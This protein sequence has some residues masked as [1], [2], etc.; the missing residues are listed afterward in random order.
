VRT[1]TA[2]IDVVGADFIVEAQADKTAVYCI[3]G[4][5]SVRNILPDIAE[6]FILHAGE[7]TSVAS[8]APPS[9]PMN[10]PNS[11]LQSQISQTTVGPAAAEKRRAAAVGW[12]IG[13]LSEGESVGL[14]VGLAA[15]TAAALAV[16]LITRGPPSASTP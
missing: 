11:V 14:V 3:E 10:T 6:V 9:A 1:P 12:H 5:V 4:M 16:P 7:Y 8:G 2:E 13:S 15:G